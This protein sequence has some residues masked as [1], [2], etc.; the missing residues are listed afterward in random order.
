M[1]LRPRSKSFPAAEEINGK[2]QRLSQ[3]NSFNGWIH[4]RKPTSDIKKRGSVQL[5]SRYV[6]SKLFASFLGN[7][8]EG[9]DKPQMIDSLGIQFQQLR[10]GYDYRQRTSAADGYINAVL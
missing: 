3:G 1:C 5:G 10:I 9:I 6:N 4:Y 8:G 2:G 7:P